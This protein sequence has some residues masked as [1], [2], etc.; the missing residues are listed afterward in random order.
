[1]RRGTLFLLAVA[2]GACSDSGPPESG[3]E[4][5]PRTYVH[6]MD[7]A[8]NSLDPGQAVSIYANFLAVNLY[9]TLYRYKYLARPYELTPNLADGM[10][11]FS[12]DG[13]EVTIR[14]KQG[15]RF[16]DDP[17]FPGGQGR[18]VTAADF[19]FSIL[20]HFDPATRAQGAWLWQGR[21]AG[22][23]AWRENGSDY[24]ANVEG[25]VALDDHTLRI[26]LTRPFPQ[27]IHTFA[28][29]YA[30]IVPREAAEA[31]GLQLGS[32]AVGSGPFMLSSFDTTRAVL[33]RNPD[34]RAEPL[35][36]EAEGFQRAHHG[37]LGLEALDG[38]E[39]PFVDRLVFEFIAEDAARWNAFV[40]GETHFIKVPV[41]QF[42]QVLASRDPLALNA[43]LAQRFWFE[44]APESGLVYTN[45]NMADP[46]IGYHDD[47]GQQERNH[48]LRCAI[49][50]GFDWA[51]RNRTFFYGIGRVF[52]GVI[53][54]AVPE[55]DPQAPM[56][57]V[58]RDVAGAKAL[59]A[60]H[61]WTGTTLPVLEYGFP[62]SVTER[63]MFEQFR[64]FMSDIGYPPEKIRPL[65]FATYGDYAQAYSQ[66]RVMLITSSWTM[67]YP[68]AEN[69]IQ[70]FYGPNASPGSNSSN[71]DN[72]EFNTLFERAAPMQPT[73]ERTR[74]F[75]A[76]NG[77]MM[78]QCASITGLSRTL[79]FL[80]S[81]ETIMQ[82]DRSNSLGGYYLRF[83][84]LKD[85]SA[86]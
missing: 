57:Y 82:P 52:P 17:A 70:L 78:E 33:M 24:D 1:M 27:L 72:A 42:N 31:Y 2:L 47:P 7:G 58:T 45:F 67:D 76:M 36:L 69:T 71:F 86:E 13:L 65:T 29:G 32:H 63:Q 44:A 59:L 22:L 9:D 8:P 12:E 14:L 61:G 28:Q 16:I 48:A 84:D 20:R 55:F 60:R 85:A 18:E 41:A 56:D 35:D 50:K 15:T 26:R 23:D 74:L 37:P 80:W 4:P 21:I 46:R 75:R 39:P 66:R 40:A 11:V 34:F 81:R 64:T 49:V 83:V 30:A 43:D 54:P 73:P 79:L 38:R 3:T 10:P 6:S 53:P 68:D 77:I 25:L 62:S 19:V 5:E 51:A